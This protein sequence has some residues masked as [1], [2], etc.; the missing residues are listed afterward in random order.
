MMEE[1]LG[2][3]FGVSVFGGGTFWLLSVSPI[4]RALAD[5]IRGGGKGVSDENLAKIGESQM[6]LLEELDALRR[7]VAEVQERVD[8]A[9][10]LLTRRDDVGAANRPS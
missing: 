9:E 2:L 10:R 4:G 3:M 8:F 6:A 1:V 7:E 5:R